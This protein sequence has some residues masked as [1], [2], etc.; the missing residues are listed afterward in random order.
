MKKKKN[1]YGNNGVHYLTNKTPAVIARP[2]FRTLDVFQEFNIF[3]CIMIVN[4]LDEAFI[5][6]RIGVSR[7]RSEERSIYVEVCMR[8]LPYIHIKIREQIKC[9]K[10]EIDWFSSMI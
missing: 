5:E 10:T 9:Y 3:F 2:N 4:E 7:R 8:K 1:V 6:K